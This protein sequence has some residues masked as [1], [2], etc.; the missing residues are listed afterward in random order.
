[1]TDFVEMPLLPK[2]DAAHGGRFDYDTASTVHQLFTDAAK[3]LEGQAGS[4][5]SFAE[6]GG[7]DFKGHF[8]QVFSTNATTA[9]GDAENLASALRYVADAITKMVTAGHKEDARRKKNNDWVRQHNERSLWDKMVDSVTGSE[10]PRPTDGKPTKGPS[11]GSW[12]K[13][14]RSRQAPAAGSGG[15][16]GGGTSSARPENLRSF[17]TGTGRLNQALHGQAAKL[18]TALSSFTKHCGWATIDAD[19]V[20][21]SYEKYL[22][23]NTTDAHWATTLAAAFERAGGSG[24]V[25]SLPD[26]A[27]Q[28][29][30]KAAKVP[31]SRTPLEIDPPTAKGALPTSGYADDPVNTTT[32][33]FIEP[34]CDLGFAGLAAGLSVTRTYNSVE[35]GAGLFGVGWSSVLDQALSLDGESARWQRADGRVIV[36]PRQGAGWERASRDNFW[37]AR[38]HGDQ[39]CFAG[40]AERGDADGLLVARDNAGSWWAFSAAGRWLG[41]GQGLGRTVSV[42]RGADGRPV[43]LAHSRGRR[44]DVEYRDGL[45]AAVSA[46]DGRRVAYS[47]QDGRLTGARGAGGARRYEWDDDGLLCAVV[48]AAGVVEVANTYDADRRVATQTS[49]FGRTSRYS[50]LPGRATVVSDADGGRAD[51]WLYD[52]RGRLVGSVDSHGQ[53]QSMSWD[54]HGN[55]V[56]VTERDG[57]TTLNSYDERGR[58]IRSVSPEGADVSY[59]WDEQDRPIST[60]TAEGASVAFSYDDPLSRDPSQITDPLGGITRLSWQDGLLQHV[61]DPVEVS[62]DLD[63][64]DAGNL[65]EVRDGLGH[66]TRFEWDEAGRLIRITSPLG[67]QTHYEWDDASRPICRQDPDGAVW[68][69]E[70][71]GAGRQTAVIDPAG[72]RTVTEYGPNGQVARVTDPLGRVTEQEFDDLGNPASLE[73]PGGAAWR[74]GHDSLSRLTGLTDP[75][76]GRWIQEYTRTGALSAVVDPA[77]VRTTASTDRAAGTTSVRDA[78]TATTWRVDHLGRPVAVEHPDGSHE[79]ARYD[80]AGNVVEVVD[81]DGGRTRVERDVAGRVTAVASPMGAVTRFSYDGCGRPWKMVDPAGGVTELEYDADQ[82]IVSRRLPDGTAEEFGHDPMGRLTEQRMPGGGVVR[83]RYDVCGRVT[84]CQDPVHGT[85]RFSYNLAGELTET[86]NAVGGRTRFDYD[87]GGRLARVLDPA[88]GLTEY[89][90]TGLDSV[91]SVTDQL[92]RVTRAHYDPAGRLTSLR[93]PDGGVTDWRFDRAGRLSSMAVDGRELVAWEEDPAHRTLVVTDRTRPDTRVVT[94]R[95]EYDDVGRLV[96]RDRGQTGQSWRWDADGRCTEFIDP[97][98]RSTLYSYDEAGRLTGMRTPGLDPL[99]ASWGAGGLEAVRAGDL[100]LAWPRRDLAVEHTSEG[101]AVEASTRIERDPQGRITAVSTGGSTTRYGYDA[102]G[103]LTSAVTEVA[104]HVTERRWSYDAAGRMVAESGPDGRLEY[105]YDAAGQ[106]VTA[107][108]PE[109]IRRYGYDEQG[110]R[111]R[112]QGPDGE[113][114]EWAWSPTG[115]LAGITVT[116]KGVEP[117]IH[118]LWTDALGEPAEVDGT[119]LWWDTASAVPGLTAVGDVPVARAPGGLTGAGG[120][121][122]AAGWRPGRATDPGDPWGVGMLSGAEGALPAGV[123]LTGSGSLS[124]AGLEMLGAR[125]YDPA[126]RGFLSVDPL[127]PELGAGM[128]ANPYAYAGDNPLGLLD[129]LGLRPMTDADLKAFDDNNRTPFGGAGNWFKNN[130]EYIAGGAAVAAGVAAMFVPGLNVV[131]AAAISGALLSGGVSTISQK[132]QGGVDWK[133]VGLNALVGGATGA[134]TGGIGVWGKGVMLAAKGATVSNAVRAV[135]VNAGVNGTVGAGSG[136]LS[137]LVEKKGHIGNG[138]EFAGSVAGGAFSSAVGGLAGPAGGSI[139]QKFS[140]PVSGFLSKAATAG[141]S[142]LSSGAGSAVDDIVSGK[143]VDARKAGASTLTGTIL[144]PISARAGKNLPTEKKVPTLQAVPN[145]AT[146]SLRG[147]FDWGRTNSRGLWTQSIVGAGVGIA[148][149]TAVAAYNRFLR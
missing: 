133:S 72:A 146:R 18:K 134:A 136:A 139:A 113:V 27:L 5:K 125:V 103:R 108:G 87:E 31:P 105:S 35:T 135:G 98:G 92:G 11:F 110:R 70:Y 50:Y 21:S 131:A 40:L 104:G 20:I 43:R 39:A 88:G 147:V 143:Q 25:T 94:H 120:R 112:C 101:D 26:A 67:S 6:N 86:I 32:G 34:E 97:S 15:G 116:R 82:R 111:V 100:G 58:L 140:R 114:T 56:M 80:A 16:G 121:W 60:S 41:S 93:A 83:W 12:D 44:V 63:Y 46:D 106:L 132:A 90:C 96:H 64:D 102:A 55:L 14:V 38:E 29:A 51:T 62:A 115:A 130:W 28:A 69:F 71:D 99:S 78:F 10:E 36:F 57:S 23:N 77:G 149:D 9:A 148:T 68:R 123:G 107:S 42:L 137:H 109:G 1:M 37:L 119:T 79:T 54:R 129:P 7:K 95:L 53:R 142:G 48:S 3:N 65:A 138:W 13:P 59:T 49:P 52:A 73:L 124:V 2:S 8:A 144:S 75:D 118:R 76:G 30:L 45:V 145:S 81:A 17:A 19:G 84:W 33:N 47:Y 66:R 89:T 22:A 128:E 141:L 126:T 85:R 122:Q 127:A 91:A 117:Q 24:T 74:F 4:R 61:A